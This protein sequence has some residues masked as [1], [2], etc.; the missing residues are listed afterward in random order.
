[1]A[2]IELPEEDHS[3][4]LPNWIGDEVTGDPKW[5]K[6]RMIEKRFQSFSDFNSQD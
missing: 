4:H 5:S 2:E 6:V 1:L 3:V